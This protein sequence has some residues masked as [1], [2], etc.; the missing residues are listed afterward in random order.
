MDISIRDRW[1]GAVCYLTIL[2]FIPIFVKNKS[3]FLARHCRQGF[4]LLFAEV[5]LL[6]LL[7][8]IEATIGRIPIL[9]LLISIIL[10]LV[11]FIV[12]LTLSVLGFIKALSGED[13]RL[14]VLDEFA[15]KVP[16]S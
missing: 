4:I 10:H 11:F 9:G 1:L 5:V 14:P 3:E 6:L 12:F 7:A 16:I 15:D 13:W 8:A 2:V